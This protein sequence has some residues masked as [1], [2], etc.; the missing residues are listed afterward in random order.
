MADDF[1][2]K[3]MDE[4]TEKLNRYVRALVR[5]KKGK[6]AQAFCEEKYPQIALTG[7]LKRVIS[8]RMAQDGEKD[9]EAAWENPY[10]I[11][12]DRLSGKMEI[13]DPLSG[14]EPA[15]TIS[16]HAGE[17]V[18][19]KLRRD[20]SGE[21]EVSVCVPGKEG[22]SEVNW[23]DPDMPDG[24]EEAEPLRFTPERLGAF[25]RAAE[26]VF[27]NAHEFTEWAKIKC[28]RL[29]EKYKYLDYPKKDVY[30]KV[31]VYWWSDWLDNASEK[32]LSDLEFVKKL[33]SKRGECF[34]HAPEAVRAD[35]KT[36]LKAIKDFS[37]AI[38]FA[39]EDLQNDRG[40]VLQALDADSGVFEYVKDKFKDDRK[41]AL[42]AVK[43]RGW[44]LEYA[45]ERLKNDPEL[46]EAALAD[47]ISY[48]RYAPP[49]LRD[50][51]EYVM[52]V[53]AERGDL[54][55]VLSERLRGDREV[56]LAAVTADGTALQYAPEEIRSDREVVLTAVEN[57]GKALE[58]ASEELRGDK[59]IV[60]AA[61]NSDG[62]AL[63]Y[64]SD[65]LRDDRELALEAIRRDGNAY[66]DVSRRLRRDPEVAKA[67]VSA[68]G[69][70]IFE[71]L[72]EELRGDVAFVVFL[73][74]EVKEQLPDTEDYGFFADGTSEYYREFER[75]EDAFCETV[76]GI[77]PEKLKLDPAL[78]ERIC[79]LAVAI[80]D[81]Y[82]DEGDYPYEDSH[83]RLPDRLKEFFE[84][85]GI[86]YS[87]AIDRSIEVREAKK[88]H[89]KEYGEDIPLNEQLF[90]RTADWYEWFA[91]QMLRRDGPEAV[92][93]YLG[94]NGRWVDHVMEEFVKRLC[95]NWEGL[96]H[97]DE[98]WRDEDYEV[99]LDKA[100]EEIGRRLSARMTVKRA[101]YEYYYSENVKVFVNEKIRFKLV[102]EFPLKI[103][104]LWVND[105][106]TDRERGFWVAPDRLDVFCGMAEYIQD[107][108][109]AYEKRAEE[110]AAKLL[111]EYTK[112]A[113]R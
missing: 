85:N 34:S 99:D 6:K 27:D 103:L 95:A 74:E 64:A 17:G 51:K 77:P 61:I 35:R 62:C 58:Y 65:G 78:V 66:Y 53:V 108:Y 9:A 88:Y 106:D 47:D 101:K 55:A 80:D 22:G 87:D 93:S 48:F 26:Y 91:E 31:P 97:D 25:C 18:V 32:D 46:I 70:E 94:P 59:Q 8:G 5:E 110:L 11:V 12:R 30:D 28:W 4:A 10:E 44:N 52:N 84:E 49:E 40:F 33:V 39:S 29:W 45:S 41:V 21:C 3:R 112:S 56:A 23:T 81:A 92:R 107:N 96:F 82:Y 98:L 100:Y 69:S 38:T 109:A 73:L 113:L 90:L 60:R 2:R 67:A 36:A 68:A 75:S 1:T 20:D 13:A 54:L 57:T 89:P 102:R 16:I 111:G 14:A 76:E 15:G 105:Y 42:A 83:T 37:Y 50:N 79:A 7:F 72:P 43:K 104:E 63:E 71:A 24:K 19:L 86:P